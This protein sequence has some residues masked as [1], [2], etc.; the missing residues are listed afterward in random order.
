VSAYPLRDRAFVAYNEAFFEIIDAMSITDFFAWYDSDNGRR[1][2]CKLSCMLL[3]Q[4]IDHLR[5]VDANEFPM[6][7]NVEQRAA[8]LDDLRTPINDPVPACLSLQQSLQLAECLQELGNCLAV[9]PPDLLPPDD[10]QRATR[11]EWEA[12]FRLTQSGEIRTAFLRHQAFQYRSRI[13]DEVLRLGIE[14]V[15]DNALHEPY[16]I[17]S[18]ALEESKNTVAVLEQYL[19]EGASFISLWRN[20]MKWLGQLFESDY[21]PTPDKEAIQ[22]LRQ[23][24]ELFVVRIFADKSFSDHNV[25]LKL[26]LNRLLF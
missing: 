9:N 12:V 20:E 1:F 26:L 25:A 5:A 8:L 15:D 24:V 19:P 13:E 11:R 17:L 7:L 23:Q 10:R 3:V 14:G 22:Q 16:A 21:A 4:A 18:R 6:L 2:E